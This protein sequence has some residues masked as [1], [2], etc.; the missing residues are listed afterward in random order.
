MIRTYR[1]AVFIVAY[2]R[3]K[4]TGK[5]LY[6]ILKRKKHWKGWEFP[7]GGVEKGEALLKTAKRE[8]FEE[9]GLRARKIKAWRVSGRYKYAR[10]YSDRPN[11]IG[12]TYKLF[13]VEV[14]KG[15][16]KVDKREHYF[17]RW[18]EFN[19]AMKRL[20][21]VNQKACLRVVDKWMREMGSIERFKYSN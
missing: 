13:S 2:A 15:R 18:M 21:H 14:K 6:A 10:V 3:E 8:T 7:K 11:Y 9:I 19:Q 5:I 12:Q 20:T 16:I 1:P 4:K 17:G